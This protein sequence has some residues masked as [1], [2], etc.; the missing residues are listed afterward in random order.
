MDNFLLRTDKSVRLTF[1]EA[2]WTGTKRRMRAMKR[3]EAPPPWSNFQCYLLVFLIGFYSVQKTTIKTLRSGLSAPQALCI[4]RFGWKVPLRSD[5]ETSE[6]LSADHNQFP[7]RAK[8]KRP[9]SDSRFVFF[10]HS[11]KRQRQSKKFS[12]WFLTGDSSVSIGAWSSNMGPSLPGDTLWEI[13]TMAAARAAC[14]SRTLRSNQSNCQDVA[15]R[16]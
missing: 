7:A 15:K 6:R 8:Q 2:T 16:E 5:N 11:M 10:W 14:C 1:F 4:T 12:A 3:N 9:G 13:S